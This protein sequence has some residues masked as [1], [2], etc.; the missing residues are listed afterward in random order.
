ME[1]DR[2]RQNG[3]LNPN[4]ANALFHKRSSLPKFVKK[5][6][7]MK[8]QKLLIVFLLC[9]FAGTAQNVNYKIIKDQPDDIAN[10][11]VNFELLQFELPIK[12]VSGTSFGLGLNSVFNYKNKLGGE[13]TFRRSYLT[14]GD[15]PRLQ[16]ELGGFYHLT[17]KT[18]T[19]NQK[20]VLDSKSYSSGGK[21]YTSTKFIHVP[22]SLMKS[23]GVRAGFNY[24]R[25][26]FEADQEAHGFTGDYTYQFGGLYLGGLITSQMNLMIDTDNFGKAGTGFVRRYYADLLFNPIRSLKDANT[27][28]AY[29][30]NKPGML[31]WRVG[32]EFL[33]PEPRKVQGHA[34]YIKT[35][36]GMRPLDGFFMMASFG[37]SFKRKISKF[38]TYTPVREQE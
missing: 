27:E 30:A 14:L 17:S 16:F 10:I 5:I 1:K 35:E 31:G 24:N 3:Q 9:A 36:V 37:F 32:V 13:A 19:R 2:K 23:F 34:L 12:N 15:K 6:I 33:P 20:V 7:T 22:A 29:T 25:E 18:K 11:W 26:F 28:V 21:T 38:G 4:T 8:N